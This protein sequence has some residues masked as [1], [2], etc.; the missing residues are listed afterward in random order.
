MGDKDRVAVYFDFDNVVISRYDHLF[1]DGTWRKDEARG[2]AA[3]G[4]S[5]DPVAV[6]L[7]QAEVD[8]GAIIDYASSF[9]TV[10][11]TRAYADWSV[12][13]NASYRR[14]LVD[15]AVDLVQLFATSGTKNGADI[16]LAIDAVED[17]TQHHDIT[18][19]VVVAGDSDYIP[20]AQRC[21]RLGRFV[22]GIG[23][24]GSTSRALRAACDE[25]T[26]YAQL[27]GV[28][29]P[30]PTRAAATTSPPAA[31]AKAPAAKA[32]AAKRTAKKAAKKAP[33]RT[34]EPSAQAEA[35]KLLERA[36][37]VMLQKSDDEWVHSGGLKSQMQRMDAGFKEK[38]L[39]F[40]SF[41]AFVESRSDV[42]ESKISDNQQRVRL[43]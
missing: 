11:L 40:S 34:E 29:P 30:G 8:V 19:V 15:R 42:V 20:L 26:D 1:G 38:S 33:G 25:F 35:T 4:G 6:R 41:R 12:P 27:P 14:Q 17:L 22:A 24:I 37:T 3:D 5:S 23:V 43:R 21:K 31:A 16:R 36:V 28:V 13:A 39:G 7:S 32:T 18:H 10:A 9:G 2:H